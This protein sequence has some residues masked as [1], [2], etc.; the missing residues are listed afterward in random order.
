MADPVFDVARDLARALDRDDYAAAARLIASDCEYDT[1]REVL[2]GAD[3]IVASYQANSAWGRETFDALI[4]ESRVNPPTG[5]RVAVRFVDIIRKGDL[6]YRHECI[7]EFTVG[8]DGK[9]VRIV[10]QDL[11]GETEA[12][13]DFFR[14]CGIEPAAPR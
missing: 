6:E 13:H 5:Q 10:H 8:Q 11:P 9:V 4:F 12:L 7:Q 1:G 3:D 14:R 2:R